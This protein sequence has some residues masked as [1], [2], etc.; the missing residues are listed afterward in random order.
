[1]QP[2]TRKMS[3]PRDVLEH[4][5]AKVLLYEEDDHLRHGLQASGIEDIT[6]FLSINIE[7]FKSLEYILYT[8]GVARGN[9]VKQ[10][11]ALPL[12]QVK[13]YIQLLQWYSQIMVLVHG[14]CWMWTLSIIGG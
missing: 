14:F 5:L 8:A 4:V 13:K 11:G 2:V 9:P 12:V 1:M 7:E 10:V 6:D 3:D